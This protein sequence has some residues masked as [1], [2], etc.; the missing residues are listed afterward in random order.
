MYWLRDGSIVTVIPWLIAAAAWSV[1]GWFIIRNIFKLERGENLITGF[2]TGALI[3]IWEVNLIG[4]IL[5]VEVAMFLSAGL[6]LAVGCWLV[7]KKND[8]SE[9]LTD[10]KAW[11]QII[12]FLLLLYVFTIFG[13]GITLY[14]EPKNLSLISIIATG[15]IPPHFYMNAGFLMLY[16]YGFHILAASLMTLGG[17]FPWSAFDFS[18]AIFGAYSV[19]LVFIL[20]TRYLKTFVK[21]MLAAVGLLFVTGTRYLLFLLPDVFFNTAN[22]QIFPYHTASSIPFSEYLSRKSVASPNMAVP[23]INGFMNGN[24][25]LS[26]MVYMQSGSYAVHMTIIILLWLLVGRSTTKWT[27]LLYAVILASWALAWESSYLLI[28][29][30]TGVLIIF[31]WIKTKK[32]KLDHPFIL[33]A[34]LSGV[35]SIFQGGALSEV[36]Q[37]LLYSAG[38][39][40]VQGYSEYPVSIGL[41]W[42]P[43]ISNSRLGNLAVTSPV[44]LIVGLLELGPIIFLS[45]YITKLAWKRY[46]AGELFSGVLIISCWIGFLIPMF[47]SL[48]VG[49]NIVKFSEHALMIWTLMVMFWIWE[50]RGKFSSFT[51]GFAAI[52]LVLM[53]FGGIVNT[54][55]TFASARTEI[56]SD[57]IN[58]M[59]AN[60]AKSTWNDLPKDALV[61]D[62]EGWRATAL[63]GRL[64]IASPG[65][66]HARTDEWTE[67]YN[68]GVPTD[69]VHAGFN[70][71]Y[72]DK[73]WWKLM[74]LDRRVEFSAPC[75]IEVATSYQNDPNDF[76]KLLDVQNCK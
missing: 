39:T 28:I 52:S 55:I 2:A 22:E 29:A 59:D 44:Q 37:K 35:I 66:L 40:S 61:F 21:S 67:L 13:K 3:F 8:Y 34:I 69:F 74:S 75:V 46:L 1:G 63:T 4:R 12:A 43:V 32:L 58:G 47:F 15:D 70:Y 14:D 6:I 27:T 38:A 54:G 53:V 17:F 5:P 33:G 18:K 76:R 48:W 65:G 36:L 71:V 51:S 11:P 25:A 41:I 45:I 72:M 9:L 68:T 56:L 49:S 20:A 57:F 64:T 30:G 62:P 73:N 10:L 50:N 23:Y 26:Y 42:P 24:W 31:E 60:I 7:I 16:H 19:V